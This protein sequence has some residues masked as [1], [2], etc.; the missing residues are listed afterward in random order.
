M[1]VSASDSVRYQPFEGS[2]DPSL[3]IGYWQCDI[4]STGDASG[5]VHS[6]SHVLVPSG[7]PDPSLWSL[8][9]VALQ[10]DAVTQL[11]FIL[12]FTNQH[13]PNDPTTPITSTLINTTQAV[14][15]DGR[16]GLQGRF[17]ASI[18]YFIGRSA[19]REASAALTIRLAVTNTD[20]I[21]FRSHLFGYRWGGRAFF[22][23]T[24]PRV[25]PGSVFGR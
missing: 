18:P 5:G 6:L 14:G 11:S 7:Q 21:A 19:G 13:N 23:P 4:D 25:P 20:G 9:Q 22:T 1:A 8:E 12:V 17:G 16:I 15:L 3:P 10:H 2:E 24:G